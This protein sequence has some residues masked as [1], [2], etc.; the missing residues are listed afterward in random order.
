M[1]RVW[2]NSQRIRYL[3][4]VAIIE[5]ESALLSLLPPLFHSKMVANK[6]YPEKH[7]II[8]FIAHQKG[9][10]NALGL[11]KWLGYY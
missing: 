9:L 1:Q 2:E 11:W 3:N 6:F 4:V 10:G 7:N 5:N 8:T